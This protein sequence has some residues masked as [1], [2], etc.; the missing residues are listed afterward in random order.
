ML[1]LRPQFRSKTFTTTILKVLLYILPLGNGEASTASMLNVDYVQCVVVDLYG[2]KRDGLCPLRSPC[3][4][5]QQAGITCQSSDKR[6][7]GDIGECRDSKYSPGSSGCHAGPRSGRF[8]S[9]ECTL[10]V[11]V[12][13]PGSHLLPLCCR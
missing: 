5:E 1:P 12:G 8:L 6:H 4:D 2:I 11:S 7:R 9:T 10:N 13:M 3:P